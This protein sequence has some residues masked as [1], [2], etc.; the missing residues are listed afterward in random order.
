MTVLVV[1]LGALAGLGVV[2]GVL[3]LRGRP[4]LD[5]RPRLNRPAPAARVEHLTIRIA[6]AVVAAVL[7]G[8]LT[9]WPVAALLVGIGGFIAP[10]MLSGRGDRARQL[11]RVEGIAAWA[12]MLRDTLAGAGGLEQ[13]IIASAT[14]APPAIRPEVQRLAARLERQRLSTSLLLFA[15]E[16]DDATG[17]LVVAALLLAADK[18]PKRLGALLGTLAKSAREEVTMR[19]RV[20]AGR[21]RTRASVKVVTIATAVFAIGLVVLNR[22]YLEPYDDALG[23]GVLAIVGACFATAFWWLARSARFDGQERFLSGASRSAAAA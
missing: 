11:Q 20:E 6:V 5:A 12:E 16:L 15:D 2:L 19:L 21:A 13:S 14:V 4:L 9:R 8:V 1:L 23:Q 10:G 7:V 22:A 3:A 18:S 17:D